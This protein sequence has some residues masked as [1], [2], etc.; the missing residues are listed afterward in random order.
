VRSRCD[1]R[2][3]GPAAP[4]A[5]NRGSMAV[6]GAGRRVSRREVLRSPAGAGLA[7]RAAAGSPH[8]TARTGATGLAPTPLGLCRVPVP[9]AMQG[10]S[11][12]P[13]LR[14]ADAPGRRAWLVANT[15]EFRSRQRRPG[16]LL[17]LHRAL[18]PP[19][20][21]LTIGEDPL[22]AR[23]RP[24]SASS[25]AA[26]RHPWGA[27]GVPARSIPVGFNGSSR[28]TDA[29]SRLPPGCTPR[30]PRSFSETSASSS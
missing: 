3:L 11:P 30:W 28:C 24:G 1:L 4:A 25:S 27:E 15:K 29:I 13:A 26:S 23:L 5:R 7:A 20:R 14:A 6:R 21:R 9:D 18:S 2:V 19:L 16:N 8:G 22:Y 12:V 10:M 17:G